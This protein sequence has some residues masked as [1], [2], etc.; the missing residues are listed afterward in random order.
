MKR[1][2]TPILLIIYFVLS[3]FLISCN[4]STK[5]NAETNNSI[6]DT[7]IL[8]V[9]FIDVGQGDSILLQINGYT[10]L[11]DAG[12]NS[13]SSEL[14]TYLDN[15]GIK[16]I[17]YVIATHPD[18]DH[19]GGMDEIIKNYEIGSFYAPKLTKDT[20]TFKNMVNALKSKGLKINVANEDIALNLGEDVEFDFLAPIEEKYEESNNYSIVAKLVYKESSMLFMGDAENL[21]EAQ[22]LRDK[23]DV[24]T[25]VIK[26]GHHGSNSSSSTEFLNEVSPDYAII[27][28][29]KNN[30]YKHPHKETINKLVKAKTEIYRTDLLGTIIISSDGTDITT[31][32]MDQAR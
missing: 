9:H 23:I 30:K 15:N 28:C 4:Y 19:I 8:Q 17:D 10:V 25:D 24:D 13:S 29:G 3:S 18:E 32:T 5:D 6:K 21:V 7:R 1:R 20:D 12:P 27:S 2:I 22:I 16:N 14:L 26:I 31:T 11:I